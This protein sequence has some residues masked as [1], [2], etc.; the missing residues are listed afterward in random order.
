MTL[1]ITSRYILFVI[2]VI[3][4]EKIALLSVINTFYVINIY[5]YI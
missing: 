3:F 2:L 5:I 1:V 4:N